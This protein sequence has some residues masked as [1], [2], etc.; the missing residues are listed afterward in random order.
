[1]Y[2]LIIISVI[3]FGLVF[4]SFGSVIF[5]RLWEWPTKETWKWFLVWRSEC[6]KCHHKL[7]ARNL[8]PIFSRLFQWWKC[9][10]C[11]ASISWFYPFLEITTVIIFLSIFFILSKYW[12]PGHNIWLFEGYI[13]TIFITISARLL[14]LIFL[15]DIKTY[16]LHITATVFLAIITLFFTLFLWNNKLEILLWI[17]IF[18]TIFLL[19]Y[20]GSKFYVK[21]R[22]WK[23]VEWF[24]LWDVIISPILWAWLVFFLQPN[25]MFEWCYLV[26]LFIILSS[27]VWLLYFISELLIKKFLIKRKKSKKPYWFQNSIPF[28]PSMIIWFLL[29]IVLR[30]SIIW[31]LYI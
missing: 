7:E 12:I 20:Y 4:G 19:I 15:Y 6:P 1:M 31:L 17:W 3:F 24:W 25:W 27:L 9:E 21:E 8:V 18:A 11:K 13:Y 2:T 29:E 5:Y 22:Y 16:E 26:C 10:Y 23:D 28:L 30:E 14:R